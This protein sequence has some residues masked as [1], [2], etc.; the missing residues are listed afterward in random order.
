ME[1]I[2]VTSLIIIEEIIDIDLA[3]KLIDALMLSSADGLLF[4]TSNLWRF[5]II[6]SKIKQE[7]YQVKTD[8]KSSNRLIARWQWYLKY[9]F[10][11]IFGNINYKVLVI[12]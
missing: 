11:K 1:I 5:S 9:L 8:T 10:P 4:T 2:I 3:E 6:M 12:K 7:K